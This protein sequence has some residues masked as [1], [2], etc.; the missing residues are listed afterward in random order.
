MTAAPVAAMPVWR[1]LNGFGVDRQ[2]GL[3]IGSVNRAG[4]AGPS[5]YPARQRSLRS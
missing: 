1:A 4:S 2:R 3:Q 5:L